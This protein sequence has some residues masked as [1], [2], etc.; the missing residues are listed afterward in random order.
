MIHNT[1]IVAWQASSSNIHKT[2]TWAKYQWFI[3]TTTARPMWSSKINKRSTST[4]VKYS[5]LNYVGLNFKHEL[6]I[7]LSSSEL[8]FHLCEV[9]EILMY[10]MSND[11]LMIFMFMRGIFLIDL[12]RHWILADKRLM[13]NLFFVDFSEKGWFFI[14]FL[15][16][17]S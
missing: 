12:M 16:R 10:R 14:N 3:N 5:H 2:S 6:K 4:K 1:T 17:S 9:E 11:V 15:M 8:I 7:A 13:K